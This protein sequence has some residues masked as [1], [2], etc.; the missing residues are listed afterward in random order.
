MAQPFFA[1]PYLSGHHAPVRFEADAPDLIVHGEVPADLEGVFY[2]NG[3]E[4]LYPPREGEYHWFDGDGMVYAFHIAGGRVAMRNRWV[5]TEKFELEKAAGKR[6]FGLLG[7]PMTADSAVQGKRYN[8]GNTNV[9]LHGGK[10]LALMEG[11]TAVALDPRG[12]E[13]LGE[14][15]YD[16]TITTTFSAHP[17]VDHATG[18][19]VNIGALING[20]MGAAELR[21]DVI[22]ADGSVRKAEIIPMPH[23][24]LMHTFFLTENWAV[25]PVTPIDVD[26]MRF[27]KG[28]PVTAWVNDR[29][30]RIAVM[31]REGTAADVR[32]FDYEP[33]HMFHE[34]NVWEED[35]RIVADVAAADGTALFPDETGARQTHRDTAQSLRRWTIDPVGG[36]LKEETLNDRDIQFPRPDDRL[37]T[38]KTRQAFANI[39]LNSRD[40]RVE[41]MDAVLR[42]DTVS[43]TED[44]HHFGNGASAGEFVFA[45]RLGS[46]GE[47]DG[48]AMT[49]VHPAGNGPSELAIFAAENIAAGPLAR[50]EIPF[51]VPSGFHCNFYA[52]D[53]VL[54]R[55]AFAAS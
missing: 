53:S 1:H 43:G 47:A 24:A 13:T 48:Y 50:V 29:P 10:L 30:T 12:L 11:S 20:P 4:P 33:R 49:I 3:P 44:I 45:P 2:R 8:T 6:L 28:G 14:H 19:L 25:F 35:G 42:F 7:N 21:Y 16:G 40:G 26:P 41:G 37:T 27:M 9:I 31:P 23:M 38:R 54:Y 22:R 51:R 36:S 15:D 32:W 52:A 17:K 46:T 5:R 34:L 18:E 55:E 39:N